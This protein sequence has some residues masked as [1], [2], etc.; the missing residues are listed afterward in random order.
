MHE[1]VNQTGLPGL[2]F[3]FS[4][5][6]PAANADLTSLDKHKQHIKQPIIL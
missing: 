5:H 1:P 2:Y 6:A 3:Y 4:Q